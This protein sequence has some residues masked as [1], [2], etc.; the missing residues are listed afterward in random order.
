MRFQEYKKR[1][2][3]KILRVILSILAVLVFAAAF[4]V[5]GLC[6]V[7]EIKVTGNSHYTAEEI[8]QLIM[9]DKY[10]Q[11]SLYLYWK[12][13][14]METEPIPFVDE[15]EPKLLSFDK[16]E[17]HVYEKSLVGYIDYLDAKMYFDKD[18]IV[19]ESSSQLIEGVPQI[20]G[21][22]FTNIVLYEKLPVEDSKVFQTILNLTQLIKK[23]ETQPDY[24]Q[25]GQ[26]G[27][28]M[29]HYENTNIQLGKDKNL[30]EKIAQ[31]PSILPKLAKLKGT[32]HMEN[33]SDLNKIIT[34]EK[35]S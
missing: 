8:E 7:K 28:L 18:G 17:V 15:L 20:K 10:C 14:F 13:H 21:L 22:D 33:Y 6:N 29:L 27:E 35:K 25:F 9:R 30:E 12:Y 3:K 2:K 34:F 31:L 1:K 4:I 19:V 32:L 5:F 24:I 11:N 23:Y 16:V 26:T